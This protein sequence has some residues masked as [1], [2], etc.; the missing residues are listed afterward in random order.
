[1]FKIVWPS[2]SERHPDH[3][4]LCPIRPSASI[5]CFGLREP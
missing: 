3:S 2:M 1:M 5:W 4:R